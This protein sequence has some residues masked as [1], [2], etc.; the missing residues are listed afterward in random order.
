MKSIFPPRFPSLRRF[1]TGLL[2]FALVL[3]TVTFLGGCRGGILV[4]D[5]SAVPTVHPFDG[6]SERNLDRARP[7]RSPLRLGETVPELVLRDQAGNEVSTIE[8]LSAGDAVFLFSP[9]HASPQARPIYEWV[10]RNRQNVTQRG[11][12]ILIL[13]PDDPE[14]N[15]A[16]A[17]A[18]QLRVALLHDPSGWGA[19]SFGLVSGAQ[20]TTVERPWSV[21]AGRGGRV[22]S[23]DPGLYPI[24]DLIT[25]LTVRPTP[26]EDFRAI[27][28]LR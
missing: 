7:R 2:A 24:S 27:D 8:V 21:V 20:D 9:G 22:L 5:P 28:L 16:V 11:A 19:R 17:Q 10:R 13:T 4:S 26:R 1:P 6:V 14:T 23:A 12:E 3:G 25:T 15:A 18:E